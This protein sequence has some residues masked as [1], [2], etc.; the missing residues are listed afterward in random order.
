L[1]LFRPEP[2]QSGDIAH[3][4][5]LR[6]V[7]DIEGFD[8]AAN[9]PRQDRLADIYDFLRRPPA[10]WTVADQMGIDVAASGALDSVDL[11]IL[12]NEK[13]LHLSQ[14]E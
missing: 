3:S 13:G 5:E 2:K 10:D 7:F 11:Q 6:I 14:L 1:Y 4:I 9:H 8:L 12:A